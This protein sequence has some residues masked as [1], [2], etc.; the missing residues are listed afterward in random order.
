MVEFR[1]YLIK[2]SALSDKDLAIKKI[3]DETLKKLKLKKLPAFV[4]SLR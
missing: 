1:A 2:E 3:S 4:D